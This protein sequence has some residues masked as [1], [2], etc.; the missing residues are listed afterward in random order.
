MRVGSEQG[1][2]YQVVGSEHL[3]YDITVSRG[4]VQNAQLAFHMGNVFDDFMCLLFADGEVVAC[5]IEF[6][7][8]VYKCV[9]GKG[10]VLTGD[11]EMRRLLR[12]ALITRFQ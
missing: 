4:K 1:L 5:R 11:T 6:S 9:Y 7:D 10:I 8:H 12:L 3:A 2:K